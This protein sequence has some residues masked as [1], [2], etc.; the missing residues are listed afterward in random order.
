M[1]N[2]FSEARVRVSDNTFTSQVTPKMTVVEFENILVNL[3]TNDPRHI[4][5]EAVRCNNRCNGNRVR[6]S[7]TRLI[8]DTGTHMNTETVEIDTYI[9]TPPVGDENIK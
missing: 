6:L 9:G 2:L 1:A 7:V 5:E 4:A 3:D 8:S